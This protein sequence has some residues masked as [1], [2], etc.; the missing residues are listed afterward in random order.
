MNFSELYGRY[1]Q[2]VHRFALY[3]C[4]SQFLA[5]DLTSETFVH[6]MCGPTD[7]R[8]GTVKA[9]LFAITRNLYRDHVAKQGRTVASDSLPEPPD[10]RPSPEASAQ[11]RQKL[12]N[13]LRAVQTLP[14]QQREALLLALDGD[15]SYEDIA[16][17]LG[18]SLPAI[19]VRIHRARVSLKAE[20]QERTTTVCKT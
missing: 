9:Y 20:L 15:L 5:E 14:E 3:L 12:Q 1:A 8:L 2:D 11:D 19:K 18:C 7:L 17:I 10:P 4:G 6:A 16:R 13:T